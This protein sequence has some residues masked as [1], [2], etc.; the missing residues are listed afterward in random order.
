M[1]KWPLAAK[2]FGGEKAKGREPERDPAGR[3]SQDIQRL[4]ALIGDA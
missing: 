1:R 2:H 4:T 3:D